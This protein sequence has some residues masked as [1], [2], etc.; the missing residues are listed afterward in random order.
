MPR[1]LFLL[2]LLISAGPAQAA[3][4]PIVSKVE[5]QPLAAQA[6][7]VADALEYLGNPLPEADRKALQ[8][9]A[10]DKEGVAAIQ[11]VLDR[12]CLA[13]VRITAKDRPEVLAGPARPELAEQ[14]WR[15]F[16]VKV[17]NRGGQA[18]PTSGQPQCRPAASPLDLRPRPQGAA[19]QRGR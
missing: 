6:K 5:L 14:G 18:D 15:L 9:A 3:D 17:I 16:L 19:S 1:L 2:A 12:H 7:R 4:L 13:G 10:R 8:E 11:K